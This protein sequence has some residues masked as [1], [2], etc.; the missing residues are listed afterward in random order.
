[1]LAVTRT[2]DVLLWALDRPAAKNALSLDLLGALRDNVEKA[3][4]DPS[5]RAVVLTS[6]GHVFASGGD[7]REMRDKN[8]RDDARG[9][10]ELGFAV[11][12]AIAAANFPV[13]CALPGPAIGGGAELA[14]ACD[15]RIGDTN[16]SF[17]FKQARLGVTT[18]W[19]TPPRLVRLVGPSTAAR[20]LF[21]ACEVA[22]RE[23]LQLRLLD[24]VTAPGEA[25]ETAL[26]WAASIS[27]GSP[28]AIAEIKQLLRTA[29]AIDAREREL[30]A[31]VR[32]WSA[33]DH[34]EAVEAYFDRRV[35]VWTARG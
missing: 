14:L 24:E 9:F 4:R 28:S 15:L 11:C 18:A 2:G 19:G 5:V 26:G 30:D 31:F 7:L 20:L 10:S 29:N 16:A 22:S 35:P 13:V 23:A 8:S 33:K 27:E 21:T 17:A 25:V 3:S 1:M 12:E 32:T 6:T 34:A